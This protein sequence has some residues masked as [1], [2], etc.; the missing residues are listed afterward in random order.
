MPQTRDQDG[1]QKHTQ[2]NLV[3]S[4]AEQTARAGHGRC[5]SFPIASY[6]LL[7]VLPWLLWWF[8]LPE[9]LTY[10]YGN[11]WSFPPA[12]GPPNIKPECECEIDSAGHS[13][14]SSQEGHGAWLQPT[15]CQPQSCQA[16]IS[17]TI[18]QNEPTSMTGRKHILFCFK[19]Q[20][21]EFFFFFSSL[22]KETDLNSS[23][24]LGW[25]H[26]TFGI[27]NNEAICPCRP[28]SGVNNKYPERR[29]L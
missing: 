18:E 28:V 9:S 29:L 26:A 27:G 21:I 12:P 13:I 2:I 4:R 5:H 22:R 17:N 11:S 3:G 20:I 25:F 10:R 15:S 14:L 23:F 6:K 19:W 8:C 1:R 24:Q 7:V 16:W